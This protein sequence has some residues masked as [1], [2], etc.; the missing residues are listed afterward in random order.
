MN[1]TTVCCLLLGSALILTPAAY[2]QS[3][4]PQAPA[5]DA[6]QAAPSAAN[7]G[8]IV[9]T[10]Q[11]RS[12]RLLD[13]PLS[14]TAASSAQLAKQGITQPSD[15]GRIVPGFS[16]QQSTYG[17]P[18]FTIRGVGLYD[19]SIGVSPTV[20]VYVD[21]V[22]LPYL[23]MTPGAGLDLERLEALKGPQGILF[24][25][26]STGGAINYIAAK[27]TSDPH[28]GFNLTYGRF[29]Q[30]SGEGYVSGPITD[31]LTAR[32]SVRHEYQDAWQ[33]SE[34]RPDD[35][36]GERN[37]TAARLL[38]DWKPTERLKFELNANAWW[39]R[40]ETQ[41]SQFE[42]FVAARP[43]AAGGYPEA[44]AAI[45]NLAPAPRN[46]TVAD[47]DPSRDY[48]RNDRFKQLSLR[49]DYDLGSGLTLTSITAYSHLNSFIPTDPDGT[50]FDDFFETIVGKISSFSQEVR[51][52]G[53][54]GDRIKFTVGGNYQHDTIDEDDNGLFDSTNSGIGPFRY[55]AFTNV[56]RQKVATQ[57]AFASVDYKLTDTITLQGGLRYTD[58]NR[59][60]RGC[61]A[62]SGDGAL[63]AGIA[64][65]PAQ[66]GLPY[67]P[68]APG[69]CATLDDATLTNAGLVSDK[70]DQHNLSWRAGINYKPSRDVLIYANVTKGYKAGS[71]SP[72]PAVF[73]SQLA[74][75]TQESV[76]AYEA[77]FKTDLLGRK[78][79]LSGAAFYYDYRDKQILGYKSF[80]GLGLNLPALQNI[81]K[82]SVRGGELSATVRPIKGLTLSG[83]VT[84]V[85]SRVDG[86]FIAPDPFAVPLDLKGEAFPSTPKWQ[87]VSDV[88]YDFP[89]SASLSAFLGGSLTYRSST[90]AAFGD[91]AQFKI[92]SYALLDLRAGVES[93]DGKWRLQV[94][95]KNVTNKYYL[96][97]ISHVT[98][99][100]AALAGRP[101]SYGVTLS[102]RF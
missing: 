92:D 35:R 62:D 6:S 93:P 52:A 13:V 4:A 98:D 29:N 28:A 9:V 36:L 47:W 41:A 60:F 7:T 80:A 61:L 21:Q 11:K 90:N 17:N 100:I 75:V 66:A 45:G 56:A 73:A 14:I 30:V 10:A 102:T 25:Q 58:Q 54:L 82:S 99:A 84:Y 77:G 89:V 57:A 69:A 37:F 24:G 26:N 74:P 38:L 42:G 79:Q 95:G 88:D 22:P 85:D 23:A 91:S 16:Y 8:E 64:A 72:L 46:A 63:A 51:L 49:G 55:H 65:I 87:A 43:A 50:N 53:S 101:A 20:T 94:W 1:R 40:S 71:F 5:A 15:L 33:K 97:N 81:P 67:R 32:V 19:T 76:L 39:D 31:T 78:L 48:R 44:T 27:P 86:H 2:A 12:E 96:V 18:V 59:N 3:E 68:S 83:G 70:L 34:S